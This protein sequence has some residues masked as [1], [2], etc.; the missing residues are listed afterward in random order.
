MSRL[1]AA[2]PS[3]GLGL[4]PW[5]QWLLLGSGLLGAALSG[6]VAYRAVGPYGDGPFGAGYRRIP[7]P[8]GGRRTTLVHDF[9]Y[10]GETVRI[11]IDEQTG[12]AS[13]WSLDAD[14]DGFPDTWSYVAPTT[15]GVRVERDL[16]ADGAVERWD[17]YAG[18]RE[19]EQGRVEKVGF[20]LAGDGVVDAWAFH[21][22][23]G[24]IVRVDVSTGRDGVVDRWEHYENGLMVRT[25]A[26]TDGDGRIDL[27]SRYESG[28]L[29]ATVTDAD[30]DGRPDADIGGGSP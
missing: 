6:V 10:R 15:G 3:S 9:Q 8:D 29:T 1:K 7:H 26:D 5:A 17:Y 22:A 4:P 20:S 13:E 19:A 28:I 11:V 2:S 24:Q 16:D 14:G 23:D 25:E 30:G 18:V 12:R 27:W 21:G